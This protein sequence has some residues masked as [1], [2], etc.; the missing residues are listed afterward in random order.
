MIRKGFY[1]SLNSKIFEKKDFDFNTIPIQKLFLETDDDSNL[2]IINVYE[3][4]SFFLKIPQNELKEKI[5]LN[6][7][8]LFLNTHGR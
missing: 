2:S 8:T 3:K 6:F 5:Y 1:L 4:A 7:T